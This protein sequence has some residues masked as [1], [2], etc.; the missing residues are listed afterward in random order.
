MK[1]M[2]NQ[3]A[4]DCFSPLNQPGIPVCPYRVERIDHNQKYPY[5]D[6]FNQYETSR[7]ET[8][9]KEA[10]L[11][12]GGGWFKSEPVLFIVL[13]NYPSSVPVGFIQ[14]Y[15]MSS[16]TTSAKATI[17]NDLYIMPD[18]RNNGA[19]L[20]LTEAAVRFAIHNK[21]AFIRLEILRENLSAKKLF[22]SVG[23]KCQIP[24]SGFDVYTIQFGSD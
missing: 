24:A 5:T 13:T 16:S 22:E 4:K 17:V 20:K 2:S 11:R 10:S 15:L 7:V 6:L 12:M 23:F 1:E 18:Y 19:A 14:L 9:G 8:L 21:S 3:T